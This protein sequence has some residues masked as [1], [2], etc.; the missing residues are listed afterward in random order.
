MATKKITV[1]GVG[2]F[3]DLKTALAD[4]GTDDPSVLEISGDWTIR[5]TASGAKVED[6]NITIQTKAGDEARH[7]GF[8]DGG[9]NYALEVTTG[10]A[11][12]VNKTG[13]IID[14]LIIKQDGTGQSNEGVR[15]AAP[16]GSTITY[17]NLIVWADT[18]DSQQDGLYC[19]N[20]DDVTVNVEQCYCFGFGR[21]G[22]H[23]QNFADVVITTILNV[24]S[25]GVWDNG[26]DANA[27]GIKIEID[28][29]SSMTQN[30]H[31][32]WS[33]END[34][35]TSSRDY[36]E[37]STSNTVWNVS[38]SIDSDASIAAVIAFAGSGANNLASRILLES[39]GGG[40]DVLVKDITTEP[41]D[42][43]LVDDS[44]NN[45]AQDVHTHDM[46]H[47]VTI[48]STDIAGTSRPQPVAGSHD[49]GPFEIVAAAGVPVPPLTLQRPIHEVRV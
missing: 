2:A 4:G 29:G 8:D 15:F 32:T 17:K 49:I 23:M 27:G 5:D 21:A 19:G 43:R 25:C 46:D 45:D 7:K 40:L 18:A 12:Q 26:H 16:D 24:N 36:K 37:S 20:L 44:T 48:P 30:V 10:H 9:K 11:L 22:I 35:G 42:L 39:D 47:G 13:C 1:D 6:N 31:N 33:L 38:H 14:G 3:T 34:N 41:Y 28:T